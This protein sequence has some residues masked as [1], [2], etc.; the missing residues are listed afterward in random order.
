MPDFSF[1]ILTYN[2]EEH[3]PRLLNSIRDLNAEI[4]V[5][6][7]GSTDKTLEICGSYGVAVAQHPFENH[8][9][10]WDAALKAFE[11]TT[12]WLIC[13]DA[14][15]VVTPELFSRLQ[16]FRDG[17]HQDIDG[18]YF[19][20]KNYFKG[21]WL[22]YGG[23]YPKYL[24][25]M[26]RTGIGY[27]DLN[28][29]MDHRLV[30]PGKTTTWENGHITEENLKENNISFW[31]NKHNHYSDLLAHEEI[32]RMDN[33]RSQTVKPNL[34]GNPDQRT[35]WLKSLW[36]KLPRFLRPFLYFTYR[37]T[38]QLGI[39]DGKTG[40]LFHFLQGFWFRIIVD[41]KIEEILKQRKNG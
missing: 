32:E 7:S 13:L 40:I 10:Q 6:D 30:V 5:L 33:L 26:V 28:E 36:W 11:F 37:M 21:R 1:V 16:N 19:N 24:L 14:D 12:P 15:Q 8:P 23:Y 9:R 29:N 34:R 2:E 35:A 18:I 22:R 39:L 20:R 27:S 3:L 31:I 17:D 41:M 4:F 38:F 25:K